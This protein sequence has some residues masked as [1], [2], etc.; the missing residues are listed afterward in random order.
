MAPRWIKK[1]KIKSKKLW[2]HAHPAPSLPISPAIPSQPVGPS[3]GPLSSRIAPSSSIVASPDK[4]LLPTVQARLWNQAYDALKTSEP[5]LVGAY[6]KGLSAEFGADHLTP[7]TS[8]SDQNEISVSHETRQRQ[9]QKLLQDGLDKTQKQA[10]IKGGINEG[11][12]VVQTVREIAEKAVSAIPEAAVA[13]VGVCLGLQ[14]L[15]NSVTEALD[16]REGIIYVLSRVDWYWNL[17]CLLFK[18]N[19]AEQSV[20]DLQFQLEGH[21]VQLYTKLLSY[22]MQSACLYR[23]Q[24][25]AVIARDVV[26]I[27]DWAGQISEIREAEAAV[28]ND[29]AQ[30]NTEETKLQLRRL[31][32]VAVSMKQNLEDIHLAIQHQTRQ[33]QEWRDNDKNKTCMKDLCDNDPRDDKTRIEIEKG[34][35]LRDSYSWI[36]ENDTFR[37]WRYGCQS[38]L[39]WIKGDP[40]K[41]KTM[42]LC[43]IID[44]LEKDSRHCL[45][46]C[47]CQATEERLTDSTAVLRGLIYRLVDEQP[48]MISHVRERYDQV[49]KQ[50][51]EGRNAWVALSAIL[52]AMLNDP[53]LDDTVIIFDALDECKIGR[54][55]L[56]DFIIKHSHV[57]WIVSSRNWQDIEDKLGKTKQS[58]R[59]HLELNQNTISEA[60]DTYI[61][62][63]VDKLNHDKEYDKETKNAVEDYLM[64][65][66]NGTFLWVALVCQE[67]ADWRVRKRY[68]L[69]TLKSFPPGLNPLYNRMLGEISDS[70]DA[71]NCKN[72]LAIASVVYRPITLDELKVFLKPSLNLDQDE[73]E[74]IIKCCGSF[75]TLREN[76]VSFVHQS[77]K[78]FLLDKASAQILPYGLAHQHFTLFSRSLVAMS[79]TLRRDIYN[80]SAPGHPIDQISVPVPDPLSPIRYSC[81]YWVDHLRDSGSKEVNTALRD[82][83]DVHKFI[84]T[85]YLYWLESALVRNVGAHHFSKLLQDA[86]QLILAHKYP[87]E[88]APL[89]TYASALVFSA[90]N[91]LI[92]ELF[93]KEEPGWIIANRLMEVDRDVNSHTLGGHDD[94]VSSV[95]FSIDGQRLA[96]SSGDHTIK[97][98]DVKMGACLQTL[99]GHDDSVWSVVFSTDGQFLASSSSDK[100]VKVWDATTGVCLETLKDHDDWVLSA[101]FSPDGQRLASSSGDKTVK[102]WDASTGVCVKTIENSHSEWVL[103]VIFSTDGQ[104]LASTSHDRT[105]KIWDA[106]TGKCMRVLEGHS[107]SVWS[108]AFSGDDRRLASSSGDNTIRI[109]DTGTG[110]CLQILQGHSD[111]VWSAVY[112]TDNQLLVSSAGDKTVK[113]WDATTGACLQTLEGHNDSVVWAVFSA[114]TQLIASSSHDKTVKVWDAMTGACLQ[115]L[116]GHSDPVRSI[117]LTTD[118]QRLAS[119]SGGKAVKIWNTTTGACLQT[120]EGHENVVTSVVFSVDGQCLASS[121]DDKSVRI[122]DVP[123]GVC[124]QMVDV[125]TELRCISFD[126]KTPR[127]YTNLGLLD[128]RSPNP[129]PISIAQAT[130]DAFLPSASHLGYGISND[131]AWVVKDGK[132]ILWL[133][134]QYR[135]AE[136]TVVG[137]RIA[138]GCHSGCVLVMQFSSGDPGTCTKLDH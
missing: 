39:L 125:G 121:S 38:P 126:S 112:S 3:A 77:A 80:L 96:S 82:N 26:K 93:K 60:V 115:T 100:T 49:G 42:L 33:Q 14:I 138:I 31:A 55:D 57:K 84:Q 137:S 97:I 71:N 131:K 67:L 88:I 53:S 117:T 15:S 19:K 9:M 27:D 64:S 36:L 40:G 74:E 91:N 113:I 101:V 98:W 59:L 127:L 20:A 119:S 37:Q 28:R 18:E 104:H 43:G 6:E 90:E 25:A 87:I 23:R 109:W 34:G 85:K 108:S 8:D 124:L 94:E 51:F 66:A 61:V 44:E 75:L 130:E 52:A 120:L 78:D 72:V 118:G 21:I 13:W 76:V 110:A 11:L 128:L 41:G 123:T 46:Y 5:K 56:L 48:S 73:L 135:P 92:R 12:K 107:D 7:V 69:D 79:Q 30:Y 35:L 106:I 62:S 81:V 129:A 133:P 63:K 68:T 65:N 17:A 22:Q 47:F 83:G 89:Q 99:K 24:W 32:V 10:L 102:V 114:D 122:W 4:P 86:R 54:D 16:N 111:S 2:H 132:N 134:P 29:M 50:L 58:V 105:I 95:V 116:G 103:S 45:S 1:L 70:K 136:S